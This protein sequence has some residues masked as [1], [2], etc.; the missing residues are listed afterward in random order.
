MHLHLFC[1]VLTRLPDYIS[2]ALNYFQNKNTIFRNYRKG[3]IF[4]Q[5]A[6]RGAILQKRLKTTGVTKS[7]CSSKP[8]DQFHTFTVP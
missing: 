8:G 2:L 3:A 6:C 1:F 7:W 4:K 5:S